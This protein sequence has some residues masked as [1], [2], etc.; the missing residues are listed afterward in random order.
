MG[1]LIYF[2]DD[3]FIFCV[4]KHA[5]KIFYGIFQPLILSIFPVNQIVWEQEVLMVKY[6][7][8]NYKPTH[9][10]YLVLLASILNYFIM[11]SYL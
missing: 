7:L 11:S 10:I 2:N 1:W 3:Y 8:Y 5:K 6:M 4:F 9:I